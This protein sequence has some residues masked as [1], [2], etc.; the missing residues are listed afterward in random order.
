[1]KLVRSFLVAAA[2][3]LP[4]SGVARSASAAGAGSCL[5]GDVCVRWTWA[6]DYVQIYG[7]SS[8]VNNYAG[9]SFPNGEGV[10]ND[11]GKGR[12]RN[13]TYPSACFYTLPFRAGSSALVPYYNAQ[14]VG[15]FNST[16]SHWKRIEDF[17]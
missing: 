4:V 17:C 13:S 12:N 9:Y 7:W 3:V 10:A 5:G 15:I 6:T 14:W 1:M 8:N 11:V 16:E 2:F